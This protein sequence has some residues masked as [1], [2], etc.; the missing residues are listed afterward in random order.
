MNIYILYCLTFFSIYMK[1]FVYAPVR[2]NCVLFIDVVFFF[3]ILQITL[4]CKIL[5]L[6]T[7]VKIVNYANLWVTKQ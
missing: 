3:L 7:I 2:Y 4:H 6:K 1:S 5:M